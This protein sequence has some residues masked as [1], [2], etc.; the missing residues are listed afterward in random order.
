MNDSHKKDK[1]QNPMGDVAD[2]S[3]SGKKLEALLLLLYQA[4]LQGE[5]DLEPEIKS[6]MF[7]RVNFS[8]E[9]ALKVRMVQSDYLDT[10]RTNVTGDWDPE[11]D[12]L[13]PTEAP[14]IESGVAQGRQDTLEGYKTAVLGLL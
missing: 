13:F 11:V 5:T 3:A 10:G 12:V 14:A 8:Q 7:R 9:F 2:P 4:F 1:E 6:S